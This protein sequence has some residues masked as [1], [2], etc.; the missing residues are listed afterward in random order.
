MQESGN[1]GPTNER[2]R[3]EN[4]L[5]SGRKLI[6]EASLKCRQRD[7]L[8]AARKETKSRGRRRAEERQSGND[9][10]GRC[11]LNGAFSQPT[12]ATLLGLRR[13]P[14]L[15]IV[16]D[17]P[18]DFDLLQKALAKAGVSAARA[19][20]KRGI[21]ALETISHL[22]PEVSSVC[23]ILDVRLPDMS[24]FELLE[25]MRAIALPV[26]ARFVFLTGDTHPKTELLACSTGAD[27]FFRKTCNHGDLLQVAKFI[28]DLL[29]KEEAAATAASPLSPYFS[30]HRPM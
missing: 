24:G 29:A 26:P 12:T 18:D 16:E 8:W 22:E 10:N 5:A 7:E 28:D 21:E 14:L 11:I 4:I 1:Q 6:A 13:K 27:G 17:D 19:W 15:V 20:A 23:L 9:L 2:A 25:R 3:L 30:R